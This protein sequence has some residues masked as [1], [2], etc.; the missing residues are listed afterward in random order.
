MKHVCMALLLSSFLSHSD[1]WN[2]NR[3]HSH[4]VSF[5]GIRVNYVFVCVYF[6]SAW[7]GSRYL[8]IVSVGTHTLYI[9][10]KWSI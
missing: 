3:E 10:I 1:G 5:T 4:S 9:T 8:N 2:G 6:G 7:L